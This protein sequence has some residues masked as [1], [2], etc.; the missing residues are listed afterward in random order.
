MASPPFKMFQIER[1]VKCGDSLHQKTGKQ[2][3]QREVDGIKEIEKSLA[4]WP[5]LS[6]IKPDGDQGKQASQPERQR[7][8]RGR[9]S[10][11]QKNGADQ[12]VQRE[13]DPQNEEGGELSG[14]EIQKEDKGDA[15][16]RVVCVQKLG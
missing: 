16:A 2:E 6:I 1:P 7:K 8:L 10:P 12:V 14:K 4:F 3:K 15:E 11:K 5:P 9:E 13:A